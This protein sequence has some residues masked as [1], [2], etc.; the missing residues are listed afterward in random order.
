[1]IFWIASYP[2]SGNTWLRLLI[3][4]YLWPSGSNSFENLKYIE[5]FPGKKFFKELIEEN[6]LKNDKLEIFK[7][8]ISAQERINQNNQLN[9][10]KTHNFAGS[11]RDYPFTDSKNSCGAIYIIR[12]PRSVA[13]SHAYHHNYDFEKSTNRILSTKNITSN[14]G[15]IE[16]RLSWKVHYLSWKKINIPK[17]IIKYEDLLQDPFSNFFQV[18]KFINQFKKIEIDQNKINEVIKKCSFKNVSENE[19]KFGFNER[20]G[21]EYFFRKGLPD[22]WKETLN[23]DL[24]KKIEEEFA[25]EMRELNYL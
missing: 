9:I 14:N 25:E 17:I 19:K 16:A 23:K 6:T 13:I 5:R 4:N 15:Y 2:K 3:T 24:V 20:E 10:L 7:H 18:L 8:F 12:D 21:K 22:E 11:I 1:M